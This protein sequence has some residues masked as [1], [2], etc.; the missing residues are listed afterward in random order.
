MDTVQQFIRQYLPSDVVG[1]LDLDTLEYTKDSFI[2]KQL[3]EYFSDLLLK[4]YLKDGSRGYSTRNGLAIYITN[5][6][7]FIE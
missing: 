2:D 6:F 1:L 7:E 3:K 5:L 4:I